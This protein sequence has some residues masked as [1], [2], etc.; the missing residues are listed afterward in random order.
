[1]QALG[2][3][4]TIKLIE[5]VREKESGVYSISANGGMSKI[6]YGSYRFTISFPCGPENAERLTESSLRELKKIID[7][8]PEDKDLAKYKEAELQD[9]KK[10]IM[11]NDKWL[12]N[13]SNAYYNGDNPEDILSYE[14]K[15]NALTAKDVQE[16]AKKYL[17]KEKIIGVLMPEK[18]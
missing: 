17:T 18:S 11:E 8:G 9:F 3:I 6:P 15:I 4:L 10:E 2:E 16:V 14:K 13:M 1:M 7:N 5:E 12:D